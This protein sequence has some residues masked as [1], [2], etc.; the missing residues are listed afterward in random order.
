MEKIFEE[1]SPDFFACPI[2]PTDLSMA[3]GG[4]DSLDKL[5][6]SPLPARGSDDDA[7]SVEGDVDIAVFAELRLRCEC[8]GNPYRQTVAPSLN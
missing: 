3:V 6:E 1:G 4:C 5:P 7:I 8:L 2:A